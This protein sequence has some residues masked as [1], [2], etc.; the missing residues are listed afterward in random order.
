MRLKA[1]LSIITEVAKLQA[2]L[3][4]K[5]LL[6]KN[7]FLSKAASTILFV[8]IIGLAAISSSSVMASSCPEFTPKDECMNP[9]VIKNHDP[10][11]WLITDQTMSYYGGERISPRPRG[12]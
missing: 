4:E 1:P 3:N 11:P 10:A 8:S 6:M 12:H 5:E 9:D 7:T 2:H